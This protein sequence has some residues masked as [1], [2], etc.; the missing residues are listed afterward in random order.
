MTL[1]EIIEKQ[2]SELDG[3]LSVNHCDERTIA[4]AKNFIRWAAFDAYN[5]GKQDYVNEDVPKV[6]HSQRG[7]F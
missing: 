1:D 4:F 2:Q 7:S 5:K 3:Y 6:L